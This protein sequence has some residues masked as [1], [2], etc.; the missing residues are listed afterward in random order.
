ML[1]VLISAPE[2]CCVAGKLPPLMDIDISGG[3]QE[4][5]NVTFIYNHKRIKEKVHVVDP[6]GTL[7]LMAAQKFC[8]Y[9]S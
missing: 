3:Y 2:C 8:L 1:S 4:W 9:A 5:I 7:R 6:I